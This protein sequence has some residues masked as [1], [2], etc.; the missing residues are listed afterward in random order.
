[1]ICHLE[2]VLLQEFLLERQ[3]PGTDEGDDGALDG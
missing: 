3:Q 2:F 1:M